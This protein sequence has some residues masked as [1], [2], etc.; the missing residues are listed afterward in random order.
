MIPIPFA[1]ALARLADDDPM[2]VRIEMIPNNGYTGVETWPRSKAIERLR[3]NPLHIYESGEVS[4]AL[5]YG[6]NVIVIV[7]SGPMGAS[8]LASVFLK[9][10]PECRLTKE[11][12]N[13]S[14]KRK[15]GDC[16][17][18]QQTTTE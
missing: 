14:L 8:G 11:Q 5:D 2:E 10:K 9:T 12:L 1:E 16:L 7:F 3:N 18:S 6:I 4:Q 15:A 17:F 13:E